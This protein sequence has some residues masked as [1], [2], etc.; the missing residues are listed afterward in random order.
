MGS[1]GHHQ[2]S[3]TIESL[4]DLPDLD[5]LTAPFVSDVFGNYVAEL[6]ARGQAESASQALEA[7][8]WT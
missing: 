4:G 8:V 7:Q 3:N 1:N 5:F 2:R 6:G